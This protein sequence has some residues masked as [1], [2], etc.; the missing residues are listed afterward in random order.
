MYRIVSIA[1]QSQQRVI[2]VFRLG[3]MLHISFSMR[4]KTKSLFIWYNIEAESQ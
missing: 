4:I 1:T 2:P 3:Y